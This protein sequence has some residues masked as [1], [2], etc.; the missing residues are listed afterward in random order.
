M[1]QKSNSSAEISLSERFRYYSE[2]FT[3][4][5]A[6][7]ANANFDGL[8]KDYR[9]VN[10]CCQS[11]IGK[12]FSDLRAVEIGFGAKP[13]RIIYLNSRGV[14]VY[15]I[16]MDKPVLMGHPKEFLD[17]ARNNGLLRAAK[18]F[19]RYMLFQRRAFKAFMDKLRVDKPSFEFDFK[20][21]V[22]GDAGSERTWLRMPA[23]PDVI[24]SFVVFE[25]IDPAALEKLIDFLHLRTKGRN[26]LLYITITVYTGLFGN[27]L[28]EWYPH[29]AA[30]KGK[31]SEPWEHLRQ[32]RFQADSYLN[33]MTRKNYN[34]LFSKYFDI[35][36]D[37]PVRPDFGKEFLTDEIR[38]ELK[39]YSEY[40]LL[41]NDVLFLLRPKTVAAN[42]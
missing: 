29:R 1:S 28:T 17:I 27:H 18:S 10:S 30:E 32:N 33:R 2:L 9:D 31:R 42:G 40:E 21:L 22:V 41:S 25:H 23:D 20:R 26:I 3:M 36:I 8:E 35:M 34:D 16:D 5:L 37:K 15:G 38:E 14:D 19:V 7:S 24:Y 39:Q 12:E 6:G 4:Y 11:I 13:Y